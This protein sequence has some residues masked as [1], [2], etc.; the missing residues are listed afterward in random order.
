MCAHTHA[1][2]AE[3]GA[4]TVSAKTMRLSFKVLPAVWWWLS[5]TRSPPHGTTAPDLLTPARLSGLL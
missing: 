4:Y 5:L 1:R 2:W 3:R